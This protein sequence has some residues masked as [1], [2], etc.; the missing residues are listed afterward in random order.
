MKDSARSSR[1]PFPIWK[2][3]SSAFLLASGIGAFLSSSVALA[4]DVRHEPSPVLTS[5]TCSSTPTTLCLN[6]S[7]FSVAA[8][9][10][11]P[12]QERSG[13]ATSLPLREDTGLF[14]FFDDSGIDLV[15][16]ILDGTGVNGSYWVFYAGLSDVEYTITVT[17]LKNGRVQTYDNPSGSF[18]SVADTSA[19]PDAAAATAVA[20]TNLGALEARSGREPSASFEGQSQKPGVD[21]RSAAPCA[22]G[23]PT[24]C[25]DGSRFQLTVDWEIPSQGRSGHGSAVPI[26]A[27]TGYFWFLDDANV[28][29]AVKVLDGRPI[30]GHFWIFAAALSNMKYTLT[31]TDTQTG[32]TKSWDNSEGQLASWADTEEFSDS[33]TPPPPAEGLSGTWSGTI[34]FVHW[35]GG[36]TPPPDWRVT[37]AGSSPITVELVEAGGNLTGQFETNCGTFGL[38]ALH[39]GTSVF[40]SLDSPDGPGRISSG[41]VSANRIRFQAAVNVHYDHDSDSDDFLVER[42]DLSRP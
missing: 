25:V 12:D 18:A 31:V 14:W 27:N 21:P 37:C 36:F 9:W 20:E 22:P 3:R 7:R 10:R 39:Q 11:V 41:Q 17:D 13:Q 16:K 38:R 4:A 5:S 29:L 2:R 24:L 30:N 34:T 26:S 6:H 8:S 32:R 42:V 40:G 1:L 23:G 35:L 28:E 19:F 15:V 33:V